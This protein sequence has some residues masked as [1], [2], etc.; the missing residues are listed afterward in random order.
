MIEK[1]LC[2][3]LITLLNVILCIVAK[4]EKCDGKSKVTW[5]LYGAYRPSMKSPQVVRDKHVN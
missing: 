2:Y 5:D 3:G 1:A 4:P